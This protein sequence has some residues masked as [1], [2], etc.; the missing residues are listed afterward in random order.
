MNAPKATLLLAEDEQDAAAVL[1]RFLELNGYSVHLALD[2]LQALDRL[3]RTDF[4]LAILDIMLP[5]ADG[6][7]LLKRIRAK[8]KPT[9]VL[10]LTARDQDDDEIRGLRDGADDYIRKP[11]SL[12]LVLARIEAALRRVK[13][14]EMKKLRWGELEVEE[15]AM[16]AKVNGKPADLTSTEWQLL[17]LMC[18]DPRRVFSRQE[19]LDRLHMDDD[20]V[21][22]DRTVDAHVKNLR[23]KLGTAAKYVVTRR[24]LGYAFDPE[25]E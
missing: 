12:H 2:G 24:G 21:A 13:A 9:P 3:Q 10:F 6:Y 22:F 18:K 17:M 8:P 11:A 15:E 16:L 25:A 1:S 20:R 7:E 4:D 23:L 5:G 19:I 14:E